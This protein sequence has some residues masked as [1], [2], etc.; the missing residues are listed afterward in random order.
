MKEFTP[1]YGVQLW[2]TTGKSSGKNHF[3]ELGADG[4]IL[5]CICNKQNERTEEVE[6]PCEHITRGV[7]IKLK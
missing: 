2:M 1:C 4:S 7:H 6:S 3:Q 5:K